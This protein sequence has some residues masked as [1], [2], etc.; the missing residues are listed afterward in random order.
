MTPDTLFNYLQDVESRA[1]ASGCVF[2]R[3]VVAAA[4]IDS[5]I[6]QHVISKFDMVNFLA[7]CERAAGGSEMA[8]ALA[9]QYRGYVNAQP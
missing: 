9:R 3:G 2:N 5:L 8:E 4:V 7:I 6:A 1:E